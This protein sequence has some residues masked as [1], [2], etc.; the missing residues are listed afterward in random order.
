M[1]DHIL[2]PCINVKEKDSLDPLLPFEMTQLINGAYWSS[3]LIMALG[4]RLK[5]P[6]EI[7]TFEPFPPLEVILRWWAPR[8]LFR[9]LLKKTTSLIVALQFPDPV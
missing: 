2:S 4:T 6:F 5:P 7:N 3:F 9:Q 1:G 8:G